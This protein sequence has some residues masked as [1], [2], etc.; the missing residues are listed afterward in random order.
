MRSGASHCEQVVRDC[1]GALGYFLSSSELIGSLSSLASKFCEAAISFKR[2]KLTILGGRYSAES[3]STP[4]SGS[5]L[6]SC[7]SDSQGSGRE[8]G[9]WP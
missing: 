7:A 5:C 9:P 2:H 8:C 1:L 3:G 6:G 4:R